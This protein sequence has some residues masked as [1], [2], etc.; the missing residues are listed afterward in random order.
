VKQK[1]STWHMDE[2][3]VRIAGRW[4]YLFRAVDSQK[5]TVDFFLSAARDGEAAMRFL[6]KRYRIRII[7]LP[8][9]WRGMGCAVT[10]LPFANCRTK[11]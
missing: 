1:F 9:S 3:F 6:K 8:M 4:L 7:S 2:I 5:Q 11:G 10:R